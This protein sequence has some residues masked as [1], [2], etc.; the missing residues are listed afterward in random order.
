MCSFVVDVC[1]LGISHF[2]CPLLIPTT[3]FFGI[4]S[5]PILSLSFQVDGLRGDPLGF[6]SIIGF[7]SS[8]AHPNTIPL[9]HWWKCGYMTQLGP[10][11]HKDIFAWCFCKSVFSFSSNRTRTDALFP[12]W[13]GLSRCRRDPHHCFYESSH[14]GNKATYRER[15]A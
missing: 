3:C 10:A 15:R 7:L 8:T 6:T 14:P 4:P 9:I 11:T 5:S 1:S 2:C 12:K 13:P